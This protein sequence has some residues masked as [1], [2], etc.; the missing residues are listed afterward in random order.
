MRGGEGEGEGRVQACGAAEGGAVGEG[1]ELGVGFWVEGG[2]CEEGV[3]ACGCLEA[4]GFWRWV[5]AFLVDRWGIVV[6]GLSSLP[7]TVRK[8]PNWMSS[9]SG[10][11]SWDRTPI[12]TVVSS[13]GLVY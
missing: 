9:G 13:S 4:C 10:L 5:S 7:S 12:S 11:G 8:P 1:G 2:G 3:V 6:L